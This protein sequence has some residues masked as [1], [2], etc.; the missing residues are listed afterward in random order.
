MTHKIRQFFFLT[1]LVLGQFYSAAW[2]KVLLVSDLDDTIK[3]TGVKSVDIFSNY[4]TGVEPFENLISL[5]QEV[6]DEYQRQG[7]EVDI[8][9]LTAAPRIVNSQKWL[10]QNHAP[11]GLLIERRNRELLTLSGKEHKLNQLAKLMSAHAGEYSQILFFGDN[12]ENDPT[13]YDQTVKRFKLQNKGQIFIR[14]VMVNATEFQSGKE[15]VRLDGINYFLFEADLLSHFPFVSEEL[16]EKMLKEEIEF[17][18]PDFMM[19]RYLDRM[20]N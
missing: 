9:Y 6:V 2:A 7:E 16:R 19:D 20:Q 18:L 4:L 13:V 17:I 3:I 8:V 14:D 1:L 15:I 11:K 5:Y 12:G 10:I